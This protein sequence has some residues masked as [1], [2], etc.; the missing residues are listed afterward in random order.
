MLEP[1]AYFIDNLQISRSREVASCR[2]VY[3]LE[4]PH[5]Y[6]V[7]WFTNESSF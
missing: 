7:M 1:Y 4:P 3:R 6:P 2:K 5:F